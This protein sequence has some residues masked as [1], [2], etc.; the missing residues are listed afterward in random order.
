MVWS[1]KEQ[2]RSP[3]PPGL[4]LPLVW[5]ICHPFTNSFQDGQSP[6]SEQG[7]DFS[8]VEMSPVWGYTMVPRLDM[9]KSF[10]MACIGSI[11]GLHSHHRGEDF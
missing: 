3:C 1:A 4:P 11:M 8:L 10:R 7:S 6:L 2:G 5:G 9:G